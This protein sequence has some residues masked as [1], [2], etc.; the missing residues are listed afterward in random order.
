MLSTI[1]Y[2]LEKETDIALFRS[3]N[4][5]KAKKIFGT[6]KLIMEKFKNKYLKT[7]ITLKT[8]NGSFKEKIIK[9]LSKKN[10]TSNILQECQKIIV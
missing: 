4:V 5:D 10:T 7:K 2:L 1:I 6:L 8:H 9:N 3:N